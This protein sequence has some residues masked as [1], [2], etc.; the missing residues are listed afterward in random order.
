MCQYRCL[1]LTCTD[2]TCSWLIWL[3]NMPSQSSSACFPQRSM[4]SS[5][6][7]PINQNT[8]QPG[9]SP[10]TARV[11]SICVHLNSCHINITCSRVS[12]GSYFLSHVFE[13]L[14]C[15]GRI[16][17]E[18]C[19]EVCLEQLENNCHNYP[20]LYLAAIIPAF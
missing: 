5:L 16:T 11:E 14:G 4:R 9:T 15:F 10:I 20:R 13:H 17:G 7:W 8:V 18:T 6:K 3:I 2:T 12:N 19:C 1:R